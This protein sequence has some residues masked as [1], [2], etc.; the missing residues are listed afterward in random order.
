MSTP[1][2]L[3]EV[4]RFTVRRP[5]IPPTAQVVLN[6]SI[7]SSFREELL[8]SLTKGKDISRVELATRHRII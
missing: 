3:N 8:S 6:I 1:S 5:P 7:A 2:S 4:F